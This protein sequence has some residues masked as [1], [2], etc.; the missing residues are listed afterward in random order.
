MSRPA[1]SVTIAALSMYANVATGQAAESP[2]DLT[3]R[4][5]VQSVTSTDLYP[6]DP[7]VAAGDCIPMHFWYRYQARVLESVSGNWSGSRI[8]FANLQHAHYDRKLTR[9]W[10]VRLSPCPPAVSNALKVIYCV[11]DGAL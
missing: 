2:P 3:L 8:R 6:D 10:R 9:D 5:R 7:C 11:S 4:V 1:L